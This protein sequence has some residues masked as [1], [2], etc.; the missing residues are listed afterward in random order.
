MNK[1]RVTCITIAI[2]ALAVSAS[3]Q[4][5]SVVKPNPNFDKMKGLAGEWEGTMAEGGQSFPARAVVSV[6][7]DGS[8]VMQDLAPGTPH[9]MI[10]MFHTDG[11]DLLATHYCAGHNQPRM[12]MVPG[13]DP[14]VVFFDF[15]DG[16][17][18]A[19]GDGHMQSVKFTFIDEDHHYED[20]G[21]NDNGKI[22]T[23]RIDFHRKKS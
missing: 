13:K 14:N 16:T 22:T 17:N 7:S 9:E 3:A 4:H 5:H 10:T 20:W 23:A 6:V 15:M 18:I 21:Y 19:P 1:L 2:I 8:A 12:K 11:T